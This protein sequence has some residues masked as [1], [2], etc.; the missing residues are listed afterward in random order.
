MF[1][2]MKRHIKYWKYAGVTLPYTALT[3]ILGMELFD[4]NTTREYL[5]FGGLIIFTSVCIVWWWWTIVQI[6]NLLQALETT[7]K[8][9][10]DVKSYLKD[11]K[12]MLKTTHN[13]ILDEMKNADS[14]KR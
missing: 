3:A 7:E 6:L 8:H 14:R 9:F 2:K 11:T 12:D 10:L 13:P 1:E 4:L 5:L